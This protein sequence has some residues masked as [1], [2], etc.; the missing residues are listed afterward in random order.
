[1]RTMHCLVALAST[2]LSPASR[3]QDRIWHIDGENDMDAVGTRLDFLSDLDGDGL[4]ELLIGSYTHQ[5]DPNV[6]PP[7][8]IAYEH[9]I[10][11]G[12]LDEWCGEAE[13]ISLGLTALQ[14]VDGDGIQD[15]ALGGP[16]FEDPNLGPSTGRVRVFS[17]R[18]GAQLLEVR[19]ELP[20]ISFGQSIAGLPDLDGDGYPELLASAP[21]YSSGAGY[22]KVVS[23]KDGAILRQHF[24]ALPFGRFGNIVAAIGDVD[25][26]GVSDYAV[27]ARFASQRG[28]VSV[29]SAATG[30]LLW[31]VTGSYTSDFLGI[32]IS[33]GGDIDGDGCADV[34]CGGQAGSS[35]GGHLDAYSGKTGALLFRIDAWSALEQFGWSCDMVGDANGDGVGDYLVGAIGNKHDGHMAGRAT[36]YSGKSLRPIYTFYP[37]YSNA[38]L[39]GTVRGGVDFN[40][41]GINDFVVAAVGNGWPAIGGRVS[42]FAGNDL[43]L[44]ADDTN[45]LPG[46]FITFDTRG[47]S[48]GAFAELVLVDMNGTSVF[49]PVDF[50][51]LDV[52]GEFSSTLCVPDDASGLDFTL[53]SYA[54]KLTHKPKWNDSSAVVISVQ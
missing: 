16:A 1:M 46:D 41:D 30:V 52:N 9:S 31:K 7:D 15:F 53:I 42:I 13:G 44:Q 47:G 27:H 17:A 36:L 11:G 4:Q 43:Y 3:A 18:T 28:R 12:V 8:G 38:L 24:G 10:V 5:C 39:G 50:G 23:T 33:D 54:V 19:G 20:D 40:R 21:G 22:V 37:G 49:A 48:A 32:S 34:I 29:Y 45:P 26:D 2:V 14:D 51:F 35:N 25:Q 6:F